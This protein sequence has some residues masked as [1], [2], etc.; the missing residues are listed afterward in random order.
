[1]DRSRLDNNP[2]NL[3]SREDLAALFDETPEPGRLRLIEQSD[4]AAQE[5]V[6]VAV[7]FVPD[8]KGSKS[9]K[10]HSYSKYECNR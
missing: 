3:E 10:L 2:R 7:Q 4:S 1:M 8:A 9:G 5:A 6:P